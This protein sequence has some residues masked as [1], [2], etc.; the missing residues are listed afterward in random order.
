MEIK[1]VMEE[2]SVFGPKLR[3]TR[4]IKTKLGENKLFI[5]DKVEN[6]GF[7][8]SPLMIIYHFN[9][10]YPFLDEGAKIVVNETSIIPRDEEAAK[11]LAEAK[12]IS[13]P[14][15]GFKEQVFYFDLPANETGW[16]EVRLVNEKQKLQFYLRYEKKNLPRFI[17]W[18]MM[19]TGEYVLGLE[20]ANCYPEGRS[21]E[22][23]RGTLVE[24][25][26]G[27]VIAFNL[28]VGVLG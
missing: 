5:Q 14:Q 6:I 11:G 4:T 16:A 20:P 9:L 2:V 13:A 15:P 3:L 24:I 19:G 10:G 27:E 17:E 8:K 18:K 28:E 21:K 22:K 7:E 23:E 1:G 26:P 12:K 25:A